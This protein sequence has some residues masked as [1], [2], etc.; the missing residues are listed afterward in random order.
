[1]TYPLRPAMLSLVEHLPAPGAER[2]PVVELA[3][4]THLSPQSIQVYV[5][6]IRQRFGFTAIEGAP[7]LGYRLGEWPGR[8][9]SRARCPS[10]YAAHRPAPPAF[11]SSVGV[12]V[13]EAGR[14]LGL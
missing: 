2:I 11:D 14:R 10:R 13:T 3:A 6:A 9:P 12:V 7:R 1:M 5:S 4:A 8:E